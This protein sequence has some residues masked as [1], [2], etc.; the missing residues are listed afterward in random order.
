[1]SP[2]GGPGSPLQEPG[3]GG[4]QGTRTWRRLGSNTVGRRPWRKKAGAHSCGGQAR[5]AGGE[6][7]KERLGACPRGSLPGT[8]PPILIPRPPPSTMPPSGALCCHSP[9][10][11]PLWGSLLLPGV[12]RSSVPSPLSTLQCTQAPLIVTVRLCL[13]TLCSL[14]WSHPALPSSPRYPLPVPLPRLQMVPRW[15]LGFVHAFCLC[16]L[17]PRFPKR[18]ASIP[19]PC[20]TSRPPSAPRTRSVLCT[21]SLEISL[22]KMNNN[23]PVAQTQLSGS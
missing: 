6:K 14:S 22:S 8:R 3:H 11:P 12:T 23:L 15:P 9:E 4:G 16:L 7:Q 5:P 17:F 10:F 2:C 19:H 20:L 13:P 21:P 1:M 18:A